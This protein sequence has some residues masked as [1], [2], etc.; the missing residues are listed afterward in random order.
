MVWRAR[1]LK[2]IQRSGVEVGT[3]SGYRAKTL[4]RGQGASTGKGKF[5]FFCTNFA[6]SEKPQA[7]FDEWP[8]CNQK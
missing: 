6:K 4:V 2:P 5:A 8:N 1:E 3:P 7:V